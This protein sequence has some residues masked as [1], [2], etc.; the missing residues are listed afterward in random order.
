MEIVVQPVHCAEAGGLLR[1]PV[2]HG[3]RERTDWEF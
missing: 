1:R 3:E 2:E